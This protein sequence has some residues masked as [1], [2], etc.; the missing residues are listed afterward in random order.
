MFKISDFLVWGKFFVK[1]LVKQ[2][3]IA[4]HAMIKDGAMIPAYTHENTSHHHLF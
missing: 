4:K 3:T 2:S 1:R